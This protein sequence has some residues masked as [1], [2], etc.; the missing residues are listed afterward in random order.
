MKSCIVLLSG[1]RE[2]ERFILEEKRLYVHECE[3][4]F[5]LHF[6]VCLGFNYG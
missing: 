1:T 4:L 5:N 2:I 3:K 6:G